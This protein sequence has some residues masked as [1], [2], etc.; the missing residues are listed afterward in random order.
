MASLTL[1]ILLFRNPESFQKKKNSKKKIC[2]EKIEKSLEY[3]GIIYF[4]K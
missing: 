2:E 3:P 4:P 1:I